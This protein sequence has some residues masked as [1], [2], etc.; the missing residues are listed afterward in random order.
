MGLNAH[1]FVRQICNA[2]GMH[3]HL[4]AASGGAVLGSGKT[5]RP[6]AYFGSII[7]SAP[8]ARQVRNNP[9]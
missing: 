5:L 2:H 3:E 9:H 1:S 8:A 4:C 7:E 6:R